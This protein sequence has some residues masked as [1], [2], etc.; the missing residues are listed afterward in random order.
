MKIIH[1][2][3]KTGT[4]FKLGT[5]QIA[6]RKIETVSGFERTR[7]LFEEW[8]FCPSSSQ[9]TG[10]EMLLEHYGECEMSLSEHRDSPYPEQS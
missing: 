5:F 4:L 2:N 1:E 8:E 3:V 7:R 10:M 9:F 6:E